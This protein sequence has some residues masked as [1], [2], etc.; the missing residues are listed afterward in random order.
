[1]TSPDRLE[2]LEQQLRDAALNKRIEALNALAEV[3][4]DLAIPILTRLATEADIG[5]RRIGVM[6]LGNHRTENS[7]TTLK[8]LLKNENDSN[9]QSEIANSMFEFGTQSL[10]LL[11]ALFDQSDNWLVKQTIV[12]LLIDSQNP[13][14][15]FNIILKALQDPVQTVKEAGIL[16]FTRLWGTEFESAALDELDKL[17][18]DDYWRNRWRATIALQECKDIRAKEWLIKMQRDEHFRVVAAALEV[19]NH[20]KTQPHDR[21]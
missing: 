12:S 1:M 3:E 16:G 19:L 18:Q 9:I 13:E 4:S 21:L 7:L 14:A 15:L 2:Q 6:G 8:E 20:G 10:P 11:D 5:L 17:L